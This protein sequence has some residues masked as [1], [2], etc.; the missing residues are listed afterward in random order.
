VWTKCGRVAGVAPAGAA[1]RLRRRLGS[2][3]PSPTAL[4]DLV[5][6]VDEVVVLRLG[7]LVLR[8]STSPQTRPQTI[9]L[10]VPRHGRVPPLVPARGGE[11]AHFTAPLRV[12]D[13]LHDLESDV[14]RVDQPAPRT[15]TLPRA[16]HAFEELRLRG[17][18]STSWRM[19]RIGLLRRT[20]SL[21]S[22]SVGLSRSVLLR[23][24]ARRAGGG[25][26]PRPRLVGGA[27]PRQRDNE[28]PQTRMARAKVAVPAPT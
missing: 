10:D 14:P 21:N 16:A 4:E 17:S 3:Q 11:S 9:T 25:S 1:E 12:A 26:V 22:S 18:I 20:A 2:G 28:A 27:Q 13:R 6:R 15:A 24:S 5:A 8:S 7:N 19:T 23:R